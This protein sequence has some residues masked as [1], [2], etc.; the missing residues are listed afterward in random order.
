MPEWTDRQKQV[1]DTRNK[2]ILVSAAAGSGKTAVLVERII[3]RILDKE[4]PMDIDRVL[5]VT[6]TNAAATEMRERIL[7]AIEKELALYP[8]NEHLQRQQAYIHNASIT[9]IH[10][11]CLNVVKEHFND[12]DLDPSVKVADEGEMSLLKSDVVQEV[13]EAYYA[14]GTEEFHRFAEQFEQKNSD[15]YLEEMIL[16]LYEKSM[17]YPFPVEWL[18]SLMIPYHYTTEAELLNSDYVRL[19]ND[20][21]D[22]MLEN[23]VAS[24][25]LMID[26]CHN[27]GPEAYTDLLLQEREILTEILHEKHF[28]RR[29]VRLNYVF[30]RLPSVKKGECD[31]ERKQ[32]VISYR[33]GVKE[34]LKKLREKMY[35]QD[36]DTVL[37]ELRK[38]RPIM[39]VYVDITKSFIKAFTEKKRDRNVIDFNDF[40]HY[41]IEILM[42]KE[43]DRL[44]PTAVAKELADSFDEVMVDEYQD[45]NR[46]QE[47]ILSC[48]SKNGEGIY[49]RFMVGDVKQS[50]YGFRGANPEIFIDKYNTYTTDGSNPASY[51]IILDKNFRSR[52]GVIQ[53]TNFIFSKIMHSS[54]GG[55]NY[56]KENQLYCGADY[57]D[58]R[59]AADRIG[60]KTEL[61]LVNADGETTDYDDE[62]TGEEINYDMEGADETAEDMKGTAKELEA[63]VIAARIKELVNPDTG[64]LV[65]DKELGDYRPAVYSDI[66]ILVRSIAGVG[67]LINDELMKNGIPGS[68]TSKSGYFKTLEI[69]TIMNYLKIIDNPLQD[70]P[71][72]AVLKS[73]MVAISDEE[74]ARIRCC[75]EKEESLYE[76][77]LAYLKENRDKRLETF[78]DNLDE[79]RF[80]VTYLSIYDLLSEILDR[81]NYYHYVKAMPSGSQRSANID[82]LKEKAASYES[83]SYQGLFHFIRYI[84]KLNKYEVD[85]GEAS[86]LSETDNAV[87]IMTIHKSKGLEFPIVF[88]ANMNKQFNLMDTRSKTNVH[89][90]MGVGMDYLD[91]TTRIKSKNIIKTA[92]N[93]KINLETIEEEM[94]LLY[95]ACTR[96]KEKLIFTASGIDKKKIEKMT[97]QRLNPNTF[98]SYGVLAGCKSLLDFVSLPL[99][100]NKAFAP[101]CKQYLDT[102]DV[103]VGTLYDEDSNIEVKYVHMSD[104]FDEVVKD[105]VKMKVNAERLS[106]LPTETI[107]DEAVHKILEN[108][109]AYRYPYQSE[110]ETNAKMSVSEI[111]KITYESEQEVTEAEQFIKPIEER[112]TQ[113]KISGTVPQFISE[114]TEM[115]GAA[116]G[117]AYHTVF[118]LFDFDIE[119]TEENLSVMLDKI[120]AMGRLSAAERKYIEIKKLM[121]FANSSLGR[122]MKEAF[123]NGQLYREAQFV[124]G[125]SEELAEEFK[126]IAKDVSDCKVFQK[127][128]TGKTNGD[129]IL[130]QGIIDVYFIE[131]EKVVIADY[132]TDR[133]SEID[134]LKYHYYVQLELYQQ[135]VEQITGMKV[136]EKIL[137][138]V[139]LSDEIKW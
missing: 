92:I 40:E 48:V 56:D 55:V 65:Y 114:R 113:N 106:N 39:Q 61:I 29:R 109:L 13:L 17:G 73:P 24:Y 38:C 85:M 49:N 25:Q 27:G 8:D 98:L 79:F 4:N 134:E 19:I 57:R 54:F 120:Q 118:E 93:T 67:E 130:I 139:K 31:E 84:E 2:N 11:F 102:D 26:I 35:F 9:T 101:V 5:V 103:G 96:A 97:S 6:F 136:G 90:D 1:I 76:N 60:G 52:E 95:V 53:S 126:H 28:D 94:R 82:M 119:P 42:Q 87:R 71:M 12:V 77:L 138:S 41:A 64:M 132:K 33:N 50:I 51:K 78:V 63:K 44:V 133:I 15:A 89:L 107:Y 59:E 122:R 137:Y 32:S 37:G 123:H 104:V 86:I 68:I 131:N 62:E 135:A 129:M 34:T 16:K 70:I 58:S 45:S 128:D 100:R 21:A 22:G 81:T 20:Y 112:E 125:I 99:G 117:T 14:E 69:R 105:K 121:E 91:E 83:G 3:R 30:D 72:A 116:R 80:K 111:K 108:R 43:E 115:S 127:P 18:D 88:V 47:A 10:S 124:M 75:G 36:I 7:R 74:L 46:I 23:A 66:V 110:A